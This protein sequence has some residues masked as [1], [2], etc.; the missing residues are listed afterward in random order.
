MRELLPDLFVYEDSCNV[1]IIR[2]GDRAIAID[3]GTGGVLKE[4][5]AIGVSGLDWIVHTHHH[6][7][8]CF[9]DHLAVAQG[10]KLAVPEWEAHYFLEAEHFW[11]RRGVFHVINMRADFFTLTESVPIA[12]CLQDF[13]QFAWKDVTLEICPAPGHTQGQV[14]LM[15]D[16][17]GQKIAFVGDLIR[18]DGQ[19]ETIY[20]LQIVYGNWD[21][22]QQSISAMEYL[23]TFQPTTLFP[24]HGEAIERPIE[25]MDRL[26]TA[27]RGW[28]EFYGSTVPTQVPEVTVSEL[29]PVVPDVYFSKFSNASHYAIVSKSGKAL[30]VDYGP[31]YGLGILYSMHHPDE[32][33]RFIPHSLPELRAVGMTKVDVAMPSHLHDDHITGFA[34]L[35]RKEGTRFWCYKNMVN[36]L[37][38]PTSELVAATVPVPLK[39]DHAFEDN[40]EVPWEEFRIRVRYSPGHAQH[41]N[42]IMLEHTGRRVAFVGDNMFN[43]GQRDSKGRLRINYN[44]IP[45]NRNRPDDHLRTAD[46]LLDF[47]P[48]VICP[49]HGPPFEV[50]RE[51]LLGYREHVAQIPAKLQAL[52]GSRN[53]NRATDFYWARVFPYEQH[54]EANR[55][56]HV[57]VRIRN[58]ADTSAT[59]ALTATLPP[60]WTAALPVQKVHI[61]AQ[62]E[63]EVEFAILPAE[64]HSSAPGRTAFSFALELNGKPLGGVCHGIGN[65]VRYPY[66]G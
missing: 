20:D 13:M 51:D 52:I 30:F 55:L 22:M 29:R 1:Y 25:A 27:M 42:T 5:G 3:F 34:Y 61:H 6:R 56:F 57:T 32:S 48:E 64:K 2:R 36:L 26:K 7:D 54:I 18:D 38:H 14:A 37:E 39:V 12:A 45:L 43:G 46:A 19:V 15:W 66:H 65:Y 33:V 10:A 8:Q 60:G 9:G 24:S 44:L 28:M 53:V 49:G 41:H 35:Q 23:K 50:T 62:G 16:R 4:L 40:E 21:G 58:Y 31:N 47:E 17:G 63:T 11:G 59:G